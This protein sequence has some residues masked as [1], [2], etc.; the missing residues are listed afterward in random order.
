MNNEPILPTFNVFNYSFQIIMFNYIIYL[1]LFCSYTS[2]QTVTYTLCFSLSN[3]WP[4][5]P[6]IADTTIQIYIYRDID[7]YISKYNMLCLYNV[8]CMYIFRDDRL[9]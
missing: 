6:L 5:S 2:L 1:F 7:I 3:S 8:S 4:L 9:V